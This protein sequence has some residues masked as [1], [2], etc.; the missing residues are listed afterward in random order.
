MYLPTHFQEARVPVLHALIRRHGLAVLVTMGPDGLTAD[1]I[2]MELDPE[3]APL[4]TL[5]GHVA[6]ANP[7]WRTASRDVEALAIF[8]GPDHY[9]S[10]AWYPTKR[11]TGKVV[12]TWNYAVVHAHGPLRIVEEAA[13]LRRLVEQLTNRFEA[14]R[15][16]PWHVTDAPEDFVATQLKAIVGIEL[17]LTRLRGKWKVSQNRMAADRSGVV[18]GLRALDDPGSRAMADLVAEADPER[19]SPASGA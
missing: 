12:P 7:V 19:R 3:P 1:H 15:A 16:Q 13:W 11:E 6:R 2:P 8:Q 17:P 4:G 10:P 9:V 5:R 14:G 18:E